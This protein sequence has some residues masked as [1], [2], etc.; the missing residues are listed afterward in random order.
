MKVLI[1]ILSLVLISFSANSKIVV[2]SLIT[3]ATASATSDALACSGTKKTFQFSGIT[4]SSTGAAEA[5][6]QASNDSTNWTNL[7]TLTLSLAVTPSNDSYS[8]DAVWKYIRSVLNSISGTGATVNLT[9][10][11]EN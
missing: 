10:S 2:R 8:V 11:E 5:I 3:D 6:V 7:D 1:L 9:V 4:S